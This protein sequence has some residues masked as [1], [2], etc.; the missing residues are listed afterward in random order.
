M[1]TVVYDIPLYLVA[2]Y[3]GRPIIVRTSYPAELAKVLTEE[4]MKNLIGVRLLSLN[5]D[6]DAL[7]NWGYS[8][9]VEL[10]MVEPSTEYSL[11]YRHAKLLDKHPV[12]VSIPVTEGFGK[13]VKLA[14]S[15]QFAVK[16]ELSQPIP[17]AVEEM[18][19]VL[20]FYLHQSSVS[21]PVEFF[22]S[23]LMAFYHN[24][25]LTL[26]AIQEEDPALLRFVTDEGVETIARSNG[27]MYRLT[28]D[29][30][31]FMANF[32]DELLVARGE[33][34][35]CEFFENCMGYFKWPRRSF[36]CEGVKRVLSTLKQ[37]A[38]ELHQ[39]LE[40]AMPREAEV[41]R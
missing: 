20:D 3:K 32:R 5:A 38:R 23:A 24:Q 18:R 1:S 9:P 10:A 26:W 4:E 7:A 19:T 13:A 14:T 21:Q 22:H 27:D 17:R 31:N 16:L 12:R 6:V 2:A 29:L 11:L 8:V 28:Y 36:S 39:D 37:A 40:T 35:G 33:C 15:L 30:D 34:Q 41:V 25:P